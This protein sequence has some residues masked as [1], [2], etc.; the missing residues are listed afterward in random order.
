VVAELDRLEA[1]IASASADDI[2]RDRVG[3]RIRA[4]LSRLDGT[5]TGTGDAR[6]T[7]TIVVATDDELF[8]LLDE[9]LGTS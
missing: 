1:V 2:A 5:R 6:E 9:E 4:L 7:D 3:D 8:E